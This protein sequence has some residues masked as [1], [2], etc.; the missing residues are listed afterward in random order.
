MT[1]ILRGENPVWAK[2]RKKEN[3]LTAKIS[4]NFRIEPRS[5]TTGQPITSWG[6]GEKIVANVFGT[7]TITPYCE[8]FACKGRTGFLGLQ[9]DCDYRVRKENV[10]FG[11]ASTMRNIFKGEAKFKVGCCSK[12][13]AKEKRV[14]EI[15][16]LDVQMVHT[17]V[18]KEDFRDSDFIAENLFEE[19]YGGGDIVNSEALLTKWFRELGGELAGATLS[20]APGSILD[21]KFKRPCDE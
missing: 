12:K 13:C 1:D 3:C 11:W 21:K 5:F 19:V 14:G 7:M 20:I 4:F 8:D 6:K 17:V 2:Q 15:S 18:A 9:G 16:S 10:D